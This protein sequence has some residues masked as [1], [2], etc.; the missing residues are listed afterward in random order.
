[1]NV[2]QAQAGRSARGRRHPHVS[3]SP[4]S[5]E[6]NADA[7][8]PYSSIRLASE[9][10]PG[11]RAWM[12]PREQGPDRHAQDIRISQ[13]EVITVLGSRSEQ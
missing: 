10:F 4:K 12:A 7:I 9:A 8:R 13:E 5:W 3:Q 11:A 6:K 1:M 2:R